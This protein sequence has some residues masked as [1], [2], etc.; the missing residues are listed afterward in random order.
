VDDV[1]LLTEMLW[2]CLLRRSGQ[3]RMRLLMAWFL[4]GGV[5]CRFLRGVWWL[6][7][8]EAHRAP[9]AS[10]G[11]SCCLS[12]EALRLSPAL[13]LWTSQSCFV[14]G[15]CCQWVDVKVC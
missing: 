12:Q 13:Y 8:R 10:H 5:D 9:R 3:R 2:V 14:P 6:L 15:R 11:K 7:L 1:V 4:S